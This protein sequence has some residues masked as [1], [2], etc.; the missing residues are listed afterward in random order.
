MLS[1]AQPSSPQPCDTN[2]STHPSTYPSTQPSTYTT[3]PS[4][5]PSTQHPSTQSSVHPSTQ[6]S[7]HIPFTIEGV[8]ELGKKA[9]ILTCIVLIIAAAVGYRHLS[10]EQ[11]E[12]LL[13]ANKCENILFSTW[14]QF[15]CCGILFI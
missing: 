4:T 9:F 14:S 8:V 15:C 10:V 3:Q 13:T 1:S 6:P 12:E 5:H 2:H 11:Q 7:T